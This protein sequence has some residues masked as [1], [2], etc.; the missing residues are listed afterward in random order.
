MGRMGMNVE[1]VGEVDGD[2]GSRGVGSYGACAAGGWGGVGSAQPGRAG[3]FWEFGRLGMDFQNIG[4]IL[5]VE[6]RV[7]E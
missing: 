7:G 2:L 5:R 3:I 6:N 4:N 1:G